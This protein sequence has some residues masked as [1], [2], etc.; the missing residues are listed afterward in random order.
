MRLSE[1][2]YLELVEKL[3][4]V[5]YSYG[6]VLP[7]DTGF[8]MPGWRLAPNGLRLKESNGR[9]D[10][11]RTN[12]YFAAL[13]GSLA[14]V[15][16]GGAGFFG[17]EGREH[18]AQ[19]DQKRRI[20][21]ERRFRWG[22]EDQAKLIQ[23]KAELILAEEPR[24]RLSAL[25]CSPTMELGVDISALNAVYLRNVPPTPANYAQRAGRAGRSGQAAL[26]VSYCAAQSP[27]DQYYFRDPT[28]M[29]SGI[30]RPPAL[31]LANR[32][33]VRAHLHAVWLAEAGVELP[34]EIPSLLDRSADKLCRCGRHRCPVPDP[35]LTD[36]AAAAMKTLL[37]SIDAELS[38][39]KAPWAADHSSPGHHNRSRRVRAFRIGL[40]IA[41]ASFIFPLGRN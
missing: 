17:L 21:R 3:L 32:D 31:E 14:A 2:V 18:T 11:R 9:A 16:P 13:Y 36:R 40:L 24:T 30:V 20:W 6:L 19:V 35:E 22:E 33:L 34:G 26:V 15:L 28:R 8:D 23:D 7:V 39:E 1:A 12:P 4:Q 37:G 10:S 25:F 41:G 27:H 29:V 38:P 5:A